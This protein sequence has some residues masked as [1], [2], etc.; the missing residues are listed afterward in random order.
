MR[1]AA[2]ET[3]AQRALRNYSKEVVGEDSIHVILIKG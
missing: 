3:A 1:T 2:R